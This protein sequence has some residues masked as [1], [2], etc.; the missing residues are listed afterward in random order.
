[1]LIVGKVPDKLMTCLQIGVIPNCGDLKGEKELSAATIFH[2][3]F[4]RLTKED[5]YKGMLRK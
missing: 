5:A 2:F 4:E 3:D 1:M